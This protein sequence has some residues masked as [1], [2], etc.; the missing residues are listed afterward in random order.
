[1]FQHFST[2][3]GSNLT[4]AAFTTSTLALYLVASAFFYKA[5]ENIFVF[6]I[7]GLDPDLKFV[8][9]TKAFENVSFS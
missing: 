2:E 8:L 1:L 7:L 9:L 5:E 3:L 4:T 6:T